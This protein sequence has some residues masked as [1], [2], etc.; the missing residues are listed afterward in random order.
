MYINAFL[1]LQKK[2]L[3]LT[4][5]LKKGKN[6]PFNSLT[7]LSQYFKHVKRYFKIFSEIKNSGI[8]LNKT[9]D[10]RMLDAFRS[11]FNAFICQILNFRANYP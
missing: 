8:E 2:R 11:L 10:F 7:I 5:F 4:L 3:F 9:K 6:I 1:N